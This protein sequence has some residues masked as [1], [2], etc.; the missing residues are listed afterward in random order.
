MKIKK[1]KK[2]FLDNKTLSFGKRKQKIVLNDISFDTNQGDCIAILGA[3]GS[4]KTTLLKIISRLIIPDSGE[5]ISNEKEKIILVNSNEKSFFWRLSVAE[6]LRFFKSHNVSMS[7]IKQY[8]KLFNLLEKKDLL[9][10]N[11]SL[12]EKKKLSFIRALL[13]EPSILLLDELSSSLDLAT[14]KKIINIIETL[15]KEKQ[16]DTVIFSTHS[17]TEFSSLANKYI[18]I[19][20]GRSILKNKMTKMITRDVF[21]KLYE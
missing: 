21:T 17:Y 7:K 1:I 2:N 13:S 12:G 6:N 9:F 19:S 3:N 4:G 18:F 15:L 10:M 20:K 11:L 16:I 8:L 5:L 14:Q